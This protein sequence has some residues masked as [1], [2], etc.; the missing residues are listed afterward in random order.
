LTLKAIDAGHFATWPGLTI[1]IFSKHLAKAVAT[2]KGYMHQ[3]R[4]HLR[5]TQTSSL[6][7]PHLKEATT[8]LGETPA[9]G[10]THGNATPHE[11]T[12]CV[13]MKPTAITGQIHSD[14]TGRFPITSSGGSK[15][16]MVVYDYDFNAILT[17]PLTT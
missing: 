9:I 7:L 14:Q 2:S 8:A 1:N 13:Y 3:E 10:G 12:H 16:I 5:L 6:P 4:Q 11:L 17:E 15:Y